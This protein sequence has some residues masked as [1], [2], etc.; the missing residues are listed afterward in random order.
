M[1]ETKKINS[2]FKLIVENLLAF[3]YGN[4]NNVNE[5]R[6]KNLEIQKS[7]RKFTDR[8]RRRRDDVKRAFKIFLSR[9]KN[10]NLI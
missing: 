8:R 5:I 6:R 10:A 3:L 7:E 2:R 4:K 9:R 1:E